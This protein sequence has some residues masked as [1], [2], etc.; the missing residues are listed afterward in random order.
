MQPTDTESGSPQSF[1][2]AF[3]GLST[4]VWWVSLDGSDAHFSPDFL[5]C[6]GLDG[7]GDLRLLPQLRA[8]VHSADLERAEVLVREAADRTDCY[9][10]HLRIERAND[11]AERTI[12][13]RGHTLKRAPGLALSFGTA[14]DVTESVEL[15][16]AL[17]RTRSQ[18][19][20]AERIGGTGSWSWEIRSGNVSW[21][22]ETYRILGVS[23]ALPPT[24]ELVLE[25]AVDDEHRARF[26]KIVQAALEEDAPYEFELPA[27]RP[28]GS[29]IVLQTRG[30]VE[31]DVA[32]APIRMV[33]TMRDVTHL[34]EAEREL[35]ER[36]ARFRVLAESSPNGVFLTNKAGQTTY[37]NDRL[38]EWFALDLE[39]FTSGQWDSRVHPDDRHILTDLRREPSSR[40]EAFDY[41]YRIV[42]DGTTRWL[43]VRTEPLLGTDGEFAGHV[44]SVQDTTAERRA[45]EERALLQ[46]QLQQ[47]QRL[48][49]VGLLAGGIA[50]DFNNLLVGIMAN[51]S[52]A[53]EL[54]NE[55]TLTDLVKPDLSA[56]LADIER[57]AD[58]AAALIK[59]LLKYAGRAP[60]E[61]KPV[62]VGAISRELPAL[63]GARVPARLAFIVDAPNGMTVRGD[64]TELQQVIMNFVTNAVDAME[65][66]PSGVIAVSVT[67]ET[68][69]VAE[70]AALVLG[71]DCKAGDYVVVT[72]KDTG[73]G[74]PPEVLSRM[75]D[76]FFSTK[77]TGR[78][79]GLASALGL[80]SSHQGAIAASSQLGVGTEVRLVLP[81]LEAT[82]PSEPEHVGVAVP[83]LGN[84]SGNILLVDDDDAARRAA[85]R[86][87]R[88]AGFRVVE[89]SNGTEALSYFES[90]SDW[91]GAVIDLSMPG[92]NGEECVAT[93]RRRI[94]TL[95]VLF[96]SGFAEQDLADRLQGM[97]RIR[98]LT[99]PYRARDLVA[100]LIDTIAMP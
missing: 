78:G 15:F 14:S 16:G 93:L 5:A 53:S 43:R 9:T 51:A 67:R 69:T 59:Q 87:L 30:A 85:L 56:A 100:A 35:Q 3:E 21:S 36:E 13:L 45:A 34:R 27:K 74:M 8:C 38:L 41:A 71:T 86:A 26:L 61:R 58:R 89:A 2:E 73:A 37:A 80:V 23:P 65:L 72:V 28:D 62:D 19:E 95:P 50:H 52:Y 11:G 91:S 94:R 39:A 98:F 25:S 17:N 81:L 32:G 54:A 49:S 40:S 31:R 44:G 42:V 63:L 47:A 68:L 1:V 96:V 6:F 33:G 84:A 92:M 70:L 48:E 97:H 18:L 99:K 57:A 77:G 60:V 10:I 79:L 75:F 90:E 66:Q 22:A 64:R 29:R 20:S 55:T 82:T 7:P 4:G 24:F 88:G 83:A 46:G 12:Q 76:P